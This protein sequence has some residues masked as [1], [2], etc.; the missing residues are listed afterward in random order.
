MNW[1]FLIQ[2]EGGKIWQP[3]QTSTLEVEECRYRIIGQ[4]NVT[5][6]C[7]EVRVNVQPLDRLASLECHQTHFRR[8]NSQGLI[9]IL[10]FTYFD[11]GLW[12]FSC[13]GDV[14]SELLGETWRVS[15]KVVSMPKAS[16]LSLPD[17]CS[18]EEFNLP[19][20]EV[21]PTLLV[22]SQ[23]ILPPK[24]NPPSAKPMRKSPQLPNFPK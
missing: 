11:A 1:L 2:R 16:C 20:A 6:L 7:V 23:K 9:V 5:N 12:E 14:M 3:I 13:C 4:T 15:Q 8:T 18:T 17:S 21:S 19:L 22:S 10:P 24:L